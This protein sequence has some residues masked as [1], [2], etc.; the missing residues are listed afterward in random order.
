MPDTARNALTEGHWD[1][2]AVLAANLDKVRGVAAKLPY[3]N[4][5]QA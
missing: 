5:F 4:G 1:S 3:M 2:T